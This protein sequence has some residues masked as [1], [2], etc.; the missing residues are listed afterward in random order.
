MIG[1]GAA[2][3]MQNFLDYGSAVA[4]HD[5]TGWPKLTSWAHT[6]LTYEDSTRF[7][8]DDIHKLQNYVDAQAGGPGKGFFQIV[9]DPFQARR[10]IND[11]KLAVVLEVEISE[12]F[13]CRGTDGVSSC[14]QAQL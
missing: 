9:T 5:T 4:P 8:L 11:G 12:P 2:A 14:S 6:N 7:E 10:V 13:G 1:A 3:P